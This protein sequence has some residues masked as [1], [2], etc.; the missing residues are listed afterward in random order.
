MSKT[1]KPFT[2]QKQP[3]SGAQALCHCEGDL[4]EPP[5]RGLPQAWPLSSQGMSLWAL[6]PETLPATFS[7]CCVP[8]LSCPNFPLCLAAFHG[9]QILSGTRDPAI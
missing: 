1:F 4:W 2:V 7:L 9:L 8:F 3:P 6:W 5:R